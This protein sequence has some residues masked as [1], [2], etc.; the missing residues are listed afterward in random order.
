MFAPECESSPMAPKYVL[1]WK[2]TVSELQKGMCIICGEQYHDNDVSWDHFVP[3]S[4]GGGGPLG[5][6]QPGL[7][8][9]AH[10]KCNSVRGNKPPSDQMVGRAMVLISH[11]PP[12]L[13]KAA[14]DNLHA[15]WLEYQ[16]YSQALGRLSTASF[17]R[18][19]YVYPRPTKHKKRHHDIEEIRE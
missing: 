4:N 5:H 16:S 18:P 11:F 14:H 2:A 3:K 19:K 17:A 13:K 10:A 7:A 8:F 1:H 6:L 9:R 15:A 12:P